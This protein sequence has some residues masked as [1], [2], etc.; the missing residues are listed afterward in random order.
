M[1]EVFFIKSLKIFEVSKAKKRLSQKA[2]FFI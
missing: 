2:A 1:A